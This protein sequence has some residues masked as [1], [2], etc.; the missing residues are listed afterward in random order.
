MRVAAVV[1]K[2]CSGSV[3]SRTIKSVRFIVRSTTIDGAIA[4]S[5]GLKP[6]IIANRKRR[7]FHQRPMLA[8]A[9]RRNHIAQQMERR[10]I[11]REKMGRAKKKGKRG[12]VA[13]YRT[14]PP[15][16]SHPKW[17][18][19]NSRRQWQV[20]DTGSPSTANG[21]RSPAFARLATWHGRGCSLLTSR[22][23]NLTPISTSR[24]LRVFFFRPRRWGYTWHTATRLSKIQKPRLPW[25]LHGDAISSRRRWQRRVP[26]VLTSAN[27]VEV[28]AAVAH[29]FDKRLLHFKWVRWNVRFWYVF[30]EKSL[31]FVI[32]LLL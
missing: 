26:G 14:A 18:K 23:Y 32:S 28:V 8:R 10:R 4:L 21:Q 30:G 27:R 7:L 5:V 1:R 6:Y 24:A 12:I 15:R 9:H 2:F 3:A 20:F 11:I 19:L 17:R 25:I 13:R 16:C 22:G 29:T 31:A